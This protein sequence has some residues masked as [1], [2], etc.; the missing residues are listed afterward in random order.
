LSRIV[1][2]GAGLIGLTAALLLERDGHRVTVLERDPAEPADDAEGLW[3][4][5]QRPGVS[6]FRLPHVMHAHWRRSMERELPEVLAE[7]ERLGRAAGPVRRNTTHRV[8][9]RTSRR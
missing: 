1:V 5:W 4:E 9:R 2:L 6:Q 7:V 3:A 8:H